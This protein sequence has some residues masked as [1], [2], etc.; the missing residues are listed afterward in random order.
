MNL[1]ANFKGT[2]WNKSFSLKQE[3]FARRDPT[4]EAESIMQ[5]FKYKEK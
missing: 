1:M 2:K 4:I 5:L 3:K